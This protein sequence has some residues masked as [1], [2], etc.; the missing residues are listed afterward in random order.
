VLLNGNIPVLTGANIRS[1]YAI[2]LSLIM[3]IS[4]SVLLYTSGVDVLVKFKV[5][6]ESKVTLYTIFE[7]I[8]TLTIA[9]PV[10]KKILKFK[11]IDSAYKK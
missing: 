6:P 2:G 3:P 4:Q 1:T 7:F 9:R 8:Y 11:A 5:N 10:E